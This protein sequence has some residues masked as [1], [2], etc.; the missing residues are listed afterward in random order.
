MPLY[1]CNV[2]TKKCAKAGQFQDPWKVLEVGKRPLKAIAVPVYIPEFL[3]PLYLKFRLR[4][5]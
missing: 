2:D 3:T 4:K 5:E 1:I